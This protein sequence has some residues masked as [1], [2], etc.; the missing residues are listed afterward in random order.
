[1]ARIVKKEEHAARRNQILDAAQRLVYTKGYEQMTVQ[2]LLDDLG[3]SKGAFY[4]YFN[5]KQALVDALIERLIGA[6]LQIIQPV[7]EDPQLTALEKLERIFTTIGRWKT[8][9]KDYLLALLR[10]WYTDDNALV[11]QKMVASSVDR[12]TPLLSTVIRQGIQ[13]GV[14]TT[15]YPDQVGEVLLSLMTSLGENLAGALFLGQYPGDVASQAE[16]LQRMENT[17]AA[18]NDAM[19][20]ILGAPD[21][22]MQLVEPGLLKAWLPVA[23]GTQVDF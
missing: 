12:I 9:Q 4:H 16:F 18:Y 10:G 23:A 2:D 6:G 7:V 3:I 15:P 19:E 1:M 14:L 13:E 20:R 21:G 11:R 8:A 17:V 5:S 22:S